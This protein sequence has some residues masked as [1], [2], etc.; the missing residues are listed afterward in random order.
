MSAKQHDMPYWR[1][2]GFY[3]F[4]FASLG[5]FIPY[6]SVYL[7]S[8][9][10]SPLEIGEL[11]AILMATKILSPNIWGWIADHTGKR[12]V[13]VRFGCLA[14]LL[15]F[16]LIFLHQ[17][18]W[19][20]AFIMVGYSF[21]WNAALPQFEAT[22]FS[23]LGDRSEKYSNIRLWGSV[24]F[25][26]SV[27]LVGPALDIYGAG[28]LP[29][30]SVFIL[31]GIWLMSLVVKE[32]DAGAVNITHEPL[33]QILM[34]PYVIALFAAC[35]LMQA[36]HGPYYTFYTLYMESN[37]YARG[38]VGQLWSLGVIAEVI[39][40]LVMFRLV[41][42]FG[43]RKLIL[44]SLL[45]ASV[46]WLMTGL[47]VDSVALMV[48]AQVLHAASFGVFHAAAIQLIHNYFKG[49]HQGKGQAL[50]SSLSFGAGGAIGSLYSGYAWDSFGQESIYYIAA[51]I[52][53]AGF[54]VAWAGIQKDSPEIIAKPS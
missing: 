15:V 41:N 25:I 11:M 44:A 29:Y 7:Q 38:W 32:R 3:L 18:Y 33:K 40:F 27:S 9:G 48:L 37:G 16:C 24:G 51:V 8:L 50:Y 6:W 12:M 2:S 28:L 39:I 13:I 49:R 1:L 23:Y 54:I 14:A 47:F 31:F 52:S 30:I 22:T 42:Y 10:F 20:V 4:Y 34:R 21:F 36:S 19:W 46:R 17:S 5:A 45:L 26:F 43:L 35:L 53:F